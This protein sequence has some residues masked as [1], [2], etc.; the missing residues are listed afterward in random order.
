[1]SRAKH[2]LE[3]TWIRKDKRPKLEPR[4]LLE[5]QEK[6]YNAKQPVTE[7]VIFDNHLIFGNNQL[8]VKAV[9]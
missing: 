8:A 2:K 9:E 1:M 4:I 3:L 5:D 7:N 6:S